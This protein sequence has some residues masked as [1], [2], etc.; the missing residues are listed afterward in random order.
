MNKKTLL[1]VFSSALILS[2]CTKTTIES[3]NNQTIAE[4]DNHSV[5]SILND[6]IQLDI[7]TYHV[8]NQ[9][10][11]NIKDKELKELL[12]GFAA[13]HEEHVNILSKLVIELNGHPPSF[14]K[15]FKGFL[16]SGYTAIKVAGGKLK[17]LEAIETNEIISNRYYNKALSTMMPS[18]IKAVVRKNFDDEKRHLRIIHDLQAKLEAK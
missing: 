14:S 11:K 6:L 17:T 16:T 7:D 18:S 10:A 8:Y 3:I 4:F 9:A 2:G 15:D 13:S 5:K 1:L 12:T